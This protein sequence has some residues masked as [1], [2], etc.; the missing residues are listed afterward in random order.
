M[1]FIN[2]ESMGVQSPDIMADSTDTKQMTVTLTS[3]PGW[4]SWLS[5]LCFNEWHNVK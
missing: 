5:P 2:L 4:L 3:K 1:S